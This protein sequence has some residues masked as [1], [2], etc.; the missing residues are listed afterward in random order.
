MQNGTN[1][2]AKL[3]AGARQHLATYTAGPPADANP[4]T[5]HA[6]QAERLAARL[7]DVLSLVDGAAAHEGGA[8]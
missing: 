4:L 7:R 6:A 1:P 5:W 3:T 8:R 2:R